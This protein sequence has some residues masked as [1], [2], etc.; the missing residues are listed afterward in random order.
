VAGEIR[1]ARLTA[2]HDY[3]LVATLLEGSEEVRLPP[4]LCSA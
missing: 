1:P 2:A 3:D 4:V